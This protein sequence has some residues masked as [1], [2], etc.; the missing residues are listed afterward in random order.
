MAKW[1]LLFLAAL[2]WVESPSIAAGPVAPEPPPPAQRQA[3]PEKIAP[4]MQIPSKPAKPQTTGEEAK[5]LKPGDAKDTQLNKGG[6][7]PSSPA[8]AK[9]CGTEERKGPGGRCSPDENGR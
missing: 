9:K 6:N 4:P 5:E 8:E 2:P 3:P 7:A 1:P